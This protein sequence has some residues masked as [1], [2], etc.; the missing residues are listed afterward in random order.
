MYVRCYFKGV[1]LSLHFGAVPQEQSMP[2][3][4]NYEQRLVTSRKAVQLTDGSSRANCS[5]E[6]QTLTF[7]EGEL[8][9][10]KCKG[11]SKGKKLKAWRTNLN[12]YSTDSTKIE[13]P[14]KPHLRASKVNFSLNTYM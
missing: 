1:V 12:H 5:L 6:R 3:I 8:C 11:K 13:K 2:N 14:G 7:F 4:Q 10:R 9:G